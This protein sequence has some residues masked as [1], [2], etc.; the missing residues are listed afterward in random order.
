LPT[1]L[2]WA[3]VSALAVVLLAHALGRRVGARAAIPFGS[4][5]AF[6]TWLVWCLGPL[7]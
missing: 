5:L 2:L 3:C 4:F 6:G 1:V 7:R